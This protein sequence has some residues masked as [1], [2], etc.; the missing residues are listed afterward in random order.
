MRQ[1]AREILFSAI[2]ADEWPFVVGLARTSFA[3]WSA[4]P[5]RNILSMIRA[6]GAI[7]ELAIDR[8]VKVGLFVLSVRRLGRAFGPYASP[9]T[10]HLDA[11]AVRPGQ[12]RRGIGGAVLDRAEEHA[13]ARGAVVL[14]LLTAA[15]N[16]PAQ[17]LFRTR[18]FLPV[19]R[20][21]SNYANR[22]DG[23]AMFKPLDA[24]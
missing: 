10:A 9:A 2:T 22:E 20:L 5:G 14:T 4:D 21:P 7:A 16:V 15:S 19:V 12:G 11:I 1:R 13:R 3:P 24:R 18:G 6:P 23:I 17:R 8:D